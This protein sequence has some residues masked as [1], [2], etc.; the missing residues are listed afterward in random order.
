MGGLI[1]LVQALVIFSGTI[2]AIV[3]MAISVCFLSCFAESSILFY[4]IC[5]VLVLL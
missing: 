3:G 4:F 2:D 1:L 5:N